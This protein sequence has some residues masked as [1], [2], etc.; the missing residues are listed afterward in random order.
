[1]PPGQRIC[2]AE[3]APIQP[4]PWLTELPITYYSL[5]VIPNPADPKTP[6]APV[7]RRMVDGHGLCG[8]ASGTAEGDPHAGPV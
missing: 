7:T 4:V 6:Y 3:L 8:A 2:S 5:R 1:M